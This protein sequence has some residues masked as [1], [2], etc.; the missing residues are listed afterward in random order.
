TDSAAYQPAPDAPKPSMVRKHPCPECG[1]NL[2]WNAKAQ[3]L[4]CPYCGTVVPWS[5]EV[6]EELGQEVVEQDL[7]EALRNPAT[8][9]GWGSQRYE[10]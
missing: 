4:K 3:S 1:A 2:E 5:D 9:R 6:R 8:G 10:A 7:A